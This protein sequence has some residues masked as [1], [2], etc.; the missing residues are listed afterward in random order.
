MRILD[1]GDVEPTI[2][3]ASPE[4]V[5][6]R[7]V[8]RRI[9]SVLKGGP[10]SIDVG[11]N[12]FKAGIEITEP[13]AYSRD[14]FCYMAAGEMELLNDGAPVIAAGGSF[15]Y[16]PTR[17]ATHR[18]RVPKDTI[19]ICAFSPAR[20]D[21]WSHRL[22]AEEVG[23]WDGD[24]QDRPT[25]QVVPVEAAE[26]SDHP[27]SK[28]DGRIDYRQIVSTAHFTLAWA[29]LG[30]GRFARP[31]ADRDEVWFVAAGRLSVDDAGASRPVSSGQ[32][33]IWGPGDEVADLQIIEDC[34]LAIFSARSSVGRQ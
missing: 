29:G 25:V 24:E 16:R 15:V 2:N 5:S 6:G 34:R 20:A 8:H 27:W 32:F 19:S 33:V 3:P 12:T 9:L 4:H 30:A 31:S 14:E 13:Y 21:S 22:S 28:A 23:R 18:V 7:Q 26:Q 11:Y 10:A 17:A 1:P